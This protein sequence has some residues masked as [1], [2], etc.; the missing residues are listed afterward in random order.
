MSAWLCLFS[1]RVTN[2]PL[3]LEFSVVI[4]V[5]NSGPH[6]SAQTRSYG[7]DFPQGAFDDFFLTCSATL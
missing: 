5:I 3:H 1:A 4:R 6:D 2:M 7:M